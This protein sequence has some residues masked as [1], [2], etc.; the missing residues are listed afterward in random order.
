MPARRSSTATTIRM[1]SQG[2]M[3]PD[4]LSKVEARDA[5]ARFFSHSPIDYFADQRRRFLGV[6]IA[7][8]TAQ[9][10]GIPPHSQP[11]S[12]ASGERGEKQASRLAWLWCRRRVH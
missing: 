12:P 9:G 5:L 7:N 3:V 4:L 8:E 11:C 6:S 1:M 2:S 10:T